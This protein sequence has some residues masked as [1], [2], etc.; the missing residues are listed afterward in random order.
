MIARKPLILLV[1]TVFALSL[2]SP[3]VSTGMSHEV[4]GAVTKIEGGKVTIK[5]SA[6]A[7]K[8]VEAKGTEL[9]NI[10]IGDQ[11]EVKDGVL[12]KAGGAPAASPP[13]PKY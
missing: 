6:G 1:V 11:V 2:A 10:K 12:K 4:K 7:E 13:G 5:D 9:M 8:T 3:G